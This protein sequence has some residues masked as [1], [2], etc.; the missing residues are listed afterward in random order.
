MPAQTAVT[1]KN[2]PLHFNTLSVG[3]NGAAYLVV[4]GA[5]AFTLR[6]F[7]YFAFE[8]FV[9]EFGPAGTYV[10]G[11]GFSVYTAGAFLYNNDAPFVVTPVFWGAVSGITVTVLV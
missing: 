8:R 2:Q 1:V 3:T 6:R 9:P 4:D 11:K 5:N 10:Q 7:G